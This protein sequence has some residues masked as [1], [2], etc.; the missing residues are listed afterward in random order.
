[1]R[2]TGASKT[3]VPLS[4]HH[5][6]LR[7]PH[8]RLRQPVVLNSF[9]T[10]PHLQQVCA[11]GPIHSS[12][13]SF[14][15]SSL[16]LLTPRR[17]T[18]RCH[19]RG[20]LRCKAMVNVEV[21]SPSLLLGVALIMSGVSLFAVRKS[22][23]RISRDSDVIVSSLIIVTGGALVFQGW[24]LDPLMLLCQVHSNSCTISLIKSVDHDM[25][26]CVYFCL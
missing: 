13:S 14:N 5:S 8:S 7:I 4:Q 3:T 22:N 9:L 18:G 12:A 19:N 26:C 10:S 6:L 21:S 16:R 11:L 24:R 2:V 25:W 1:M 17:C 23:R 15:G 20:P